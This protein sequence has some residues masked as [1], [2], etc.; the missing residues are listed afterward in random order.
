MG[1]FDYYIIPLAKKLKDC[2]V[3]GV[4]SDEYLNY[5]QQNRKEWELN[6]EK[7]VENMIQSIRLETSTHTTLRN[8]NRGQSPAPGRRKTSQSPGS[9]RRKKASNGIAPQGNTYPGSVPRTGTRRT[10]RSSLKLSQATVSDDETRSLDSSSGR[11]SF[12]KD[13]PSNQDLPT[14]M[15]ILIVDDDKITRKLFSRTVEKIA[16]QWQIQDAESGEEALLVVEK[17]EKSF[18]LIFMDMYMGTEASLLLG[19]DAV[20]EL[21]NRG[22]ESIICGMSANDVE[23]LFDDAGADAFIFKPLPFRPVALTRELI[24]ILMSGDDWYSPDW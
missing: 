17:A 15:S 4:S 3:F 5:A 22:T 23:T 13:P 19:S 1:F 12:S 21:R 20:A 11:A 16:P 2:G 10:R 24:R 8:M 9:G 14:C 6:G 18:D 7:V